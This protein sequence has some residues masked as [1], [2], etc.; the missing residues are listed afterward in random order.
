MNF[1]VALAGLVLIAIWVVAGGFIT[2]ASTLFHAT[3]VVNEQAN[4]AYWYAFWA[5]FVTWT[6]VGLSLIAA[7][8]SIFGIF[9]IFS[10]ASVATVLTPNSKPK[11]VSASTVLFLLFAMGLVFT[12][13][14]LSAL[15]AYNIQQSGVLNVNDERVNKGYRDCIIAA[16]ASLTAGGLIVI[17]IIVVIVLGQIRKGKETKIIEQKQRISKKERDRRNKIEQLIEAKLIGDLAK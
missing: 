3:R 6:L 2:Q 15:S 7:F 1:W 12:T 8:L 14:I 4:R 9:E 16:V 11:G 5:A 13:G 10:F 17:A